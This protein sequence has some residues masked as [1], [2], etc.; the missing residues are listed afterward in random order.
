[1][2]SENVLNQVV[3]INLDIHLWSGR[4]KLH[5]EDL[6]RISGDQLPPQDLASL[7]S[8]KICDPTEVAI[9]ERI[10]RRAERACAA[11]GI[12]FLGGYAIPVDR[13]AELEQT[14]VELRQEFQAEKAAFLSRY[15]QVVEEWAR[16]HPN[17]ERIIRRAVT[18]VAVVDAQLSFDYQVFRVVEAPA[19]VP[20]ATADTADGLGRQVRGLA[21][22]LFDEVAA[23]AEDALE[24]SIRG[25]SRVTQKALRPIRA[26]QAKLDGLCFLDPRVAPVVAWVQESLERLP[27]VGHIEGSDLVALETVFATL[28]DPDRVI[29]LGEVRLSGQDSDESQLASEQETDQES[30]QAD[31]SSGNG[32]AGDVVS[33]PDRQAELAEQPQ[34]QDAPLAA[35]TG[36]WF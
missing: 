15:D 3:A 21:G 22:K 34:E 16:A 10:K 4:R 28:S 30:Q 27:K 13:Q 25:R 11:I 24:Q 33:I 17:W 6:E 19:S 18:P 31:G 5:K 9:F 20:D 23:K 36:T 32:H 8:K 2:A 1:M 12:R 7:G 29:A 26:I 35:Q 14:L